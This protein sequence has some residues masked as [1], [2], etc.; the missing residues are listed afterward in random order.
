MA[1]STMG[2]MKTTGAIVAAAATR[3]AAAAVT[4]HRRRAA[5]CI[6][7]WDDINGLCPIVAR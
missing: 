5:R 1:R 3:T 6:W 4:G 2:V 7:F